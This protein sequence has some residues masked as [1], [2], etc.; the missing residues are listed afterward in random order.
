M[1]ELAQT[2]AG[3]GEEVRVAAPGAPG[4]PGRER[5]QGVEIR[6]IT[7]ALPRS[8]QKLAYG[9]GLIPNLRARPVLALLLP[10]FLL[11]LGLAAARLAAGSDLLHGQWVVSGWLGRA[12]RFI[13]GRPVVVTLR[14]SDLALLRHLP[15]PLARWSLAGFEAVTAVSQ[16]ICRAVLDLGLAE[17]KVFLTPNGVNLDLFRPLDQGECRAALGL[18]AGRPV[19]LWAGRLAPEKG[20]SDLI[21]AVPYILEGHPRARLVML[22]QGPLLAE[23]K[24]LRTQLGLEGAVEL[25]PAVPRQDLARWYNAADLVCLPSLRE[26]RPNTL[27]EALACG[28][29][30]LAT[31]V[32]GV[33]EIIAEGRTGR[34]VEPGDPE[35]LGRAAAELLDRPETLAALGRAGPQA[36]AEMGLTWAEAAGK[37]REVYE[38]VLERRREPAR[39]VRLI[40]RPWTLWLAAA[41]AALV[42]GI[43]LVR[44]W[45][46][47]D[48]G[49][50]ITDKLG[51]EGWGGVISRWLGF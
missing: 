40:G 31:R 47:L 34:L 1:A 30:I 49:Y 20:A 16:E 27:L 42:S 18:E 48:A 46:I 21:Q 17:E 2:L 28:R 23:L 51:R 45:R 41:W 33:P 12:F 8:L 32:G 25:R 38:L 36:L 35:A 37:V 29:P 39:E 13:H 26:G 14:G 6:R 3:L 22:G 5:A 44:Y 11:A 4:V 10:Q 24:G 7:Y 50:G 15:R 19:L 9:G 43:F